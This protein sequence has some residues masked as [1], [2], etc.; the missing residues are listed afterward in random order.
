[1]ALAEY[2]PIY[3]ISAG[4]IVFVFVTYMF[5]HIIPWWAVAAR[6]LNDMGWSGWLLIPFTI[7][8]LIPLINIVSGIVFIVVLCWPSKK[9][10]KSKRKIKK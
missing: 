9:S 6:R 10:I 5:T 8:G 1:M 3:Y 2:D 7:L 4:F